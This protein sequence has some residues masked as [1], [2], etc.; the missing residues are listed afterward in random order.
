MGAQ[1]TSIGT[2]NVGLTSVRLKRLEWGFIGAAERLAASGLLAAL[3]PLLTLSGILAAI[4]SRRSPLIAHQRVGEGGRLI[5]VMKIRTMWNPTPNKAGRF[6]LVE[7]LTAEFLPE[8]KTP[9][10]ARVSSRFAAWCRK[11]SIDECPQFWHVMR[12]EMALIGPRPLTVHEIE[13]YYGTAAAELLSK[14]PGITG[15]WQIEGRSRLSYRQRR[16]LD[17]FMIRNWSFGLYLKILI[18]TIPDVLT[19][20]NA[21]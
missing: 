3:L 16:R 12:G 18:R 14:R 11:Y 2:L 17:L 8:P 4:L 21:W 20:R 15:L 6:Q 13:A 19:G 1:Q 7:R 5:W 10:D 9:A